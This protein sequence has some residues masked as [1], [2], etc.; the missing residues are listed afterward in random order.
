LGTGFMT[1]LGLQA[2]EQ[3]IPRSV[4]DRIV[5]SGVDQR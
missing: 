3:R 1:A 2:E 4:V 5:R